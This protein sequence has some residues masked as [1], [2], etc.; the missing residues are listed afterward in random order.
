MG[1]D[2]ICTTVPSIKNDEWIKELNRKNIRLSDIES[3][4][5]HGQIDILIGAD[6]AGKLITGEI[7]NLTNGLTALETRLG[8]TVIGKLPK[9]TNKIDTAVMMT[10]S[11]V[12]EADPTNLW[13]LDVIGILDPIEKLDKLAETEQ[14]RKFLIETAK[15]NNEGRY[16]VRLPWKEDHAPISR[17]YEA[18]KSRLKKCVEKLSSRNLLEQYDKVFN[19]WLAERII[20]EVFDDE[21]KTAGH[22]LPHRPVIKA[23]GTTK[24]RPVF[25]ASASSKGDPFLNQCLEI[26]PN[27]IELVPSALN[28]FREKEIGVTAD[29]KKAFLQISINKLDRNVLRFLWTVNDRLVVYRH[30]RVVFGLTCSPFL[31]A[32]IIELHLSNSSKDKDTATKLKESFY[33]D[34]CI[35]SVNSVDELET[36]VKKATSI[37]N[38]MFTCTRVNASRSACVMTAGTIRS[39]RTLED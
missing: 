28:R 5:S 34:N 10:T 1:Q 13:K 24:I 22:Y 36:F 12:Q 7:T 15:L 35:T 33:V 32:A 37:I 8:W 3:T 39:N 19:Q 4:N 20:E 14:T 6:V 17:N 16:E 11:F 29:V 27:L 25:D 26:G 31:L 38:F 18:A 2:N 23:Y 21:N 9:F 30:C